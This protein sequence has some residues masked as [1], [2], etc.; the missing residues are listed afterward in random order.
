MTEKVKKNNRSRVE[1]IKQAQHEAIRSKMDGTRYIRYIEESHKQLQSELIKLKGKR[2]IQPAQRDVIDLRIK[3]IKEK[4]NT[5]IRR[6]KFVLPELR[7]IELKD[8]DGNNPLAAL[9]TTLKESYDLANK[10]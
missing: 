9:V 7:S 4:I 1:R 3:I 5:D 2:S 10:K 6:L 8:P